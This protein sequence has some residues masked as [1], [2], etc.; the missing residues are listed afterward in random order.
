MVR[1]T[2]WIESSKVREMCIKYRY[3]TCGDCEAYDAMLEKAHLTPVEDLRTIKQIAIDIYDHSTMRND[4]DYS[5]QEMVEGLIYG[6]LAECTEL[7]VEIEDEV[8]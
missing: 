2:R 6:L 1:V 4:K 3:Y 8:I 5:K 7:Y